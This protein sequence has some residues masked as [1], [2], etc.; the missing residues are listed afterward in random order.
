VLNCNAIHFLNNFQNDLLV[1][2]LSL[3]DWLLWPVNQ[4]DLQWV[5]VLGEGWATPLTG[6]MRERE[7]LQISALR[8]P[9]WMVRI[10][11]SIESI[12]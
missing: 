3:S 10:D 9:A 1:F 7:F 12:N 5:Q 8:L 11:Q 2:A 6:F 4:V